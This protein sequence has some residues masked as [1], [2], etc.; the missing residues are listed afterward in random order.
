MANAVINTWPV[1]N[2]HVA[3]YTPAMDFTATQTVQV[4]PSYPGY[5]FIAV[6][7]KGITLTKA[8][9]ISTSFTVTAGNDG[10]N[11][12]V[13]A[14]VTPAT[15]FF[16]NAGTL[17]G[18]SIGLANLPI[19]EVDMATAISFVITAGAT[20]TGGFAWTGR[21]ALTGILIPSS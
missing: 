5:V 6:A 17:T 12:N 20:G 21:L 3:W 2:P 8:G 15:T 1:Q 11:L 9:S 4:S 7:C 18:I 13:V 16:S 10:S 19:L 14:S